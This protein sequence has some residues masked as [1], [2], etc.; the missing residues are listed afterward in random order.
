MSRLFHAVFAKTL[1]EP[2][3]AAIADDQERD[4]LDEL[5][6]DDSAHYKKQTTKWIRNSLTSVGDPCFWYLMSV[7]HQTRAPLLHYY[8]FLCMKQT[9]NRMAIVELVSQRITLVVAEFNSLLATMPSWTAQAFKVGEEVQARPGVDRDW[10]LDAAATLLLH[11][12]AA[13]D[14]RVRTVFDRQGV[15]ET[16]HVAWQVG[17]SHSYKVF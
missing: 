13:F 14:R 5:A 4:G 10:L 6:L 16:C 7:A 9:P 11:N 2:A 1:D 17:R 12:A 8:R 15:C 3:A